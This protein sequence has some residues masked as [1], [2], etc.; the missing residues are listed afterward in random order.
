MP[1]KNIYL[2]PHG[3]EI[4]DRPGTGSERMNET[5]G[6]VT[7][8]DGS[9]VLV[10]ASPHG[11]RLSNSIP[12]VNTE[13]FEGWFGLK[14]KNLHRALPNERP[15]TELIIENSRGDCEEVGYVTVQGDKS[16]FPLD[17]GT[18]IPLE[19]FRDRPI[20]Y[21]G[22]SRISDRKKLRRFGRKLFDS[23]DQYEKSVSLIISADQSHTHSPN[24]PYGYSEESSTYEDIVKEAI[25]SNDFT[26]LVEMDD[27]L[28]SNAK[29]DSYWNLLVLT[30]FLEKSERRLELDYSY[31]E[32]YF[33]M[34]CAHSYR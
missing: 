9:D 13:R 25:V 33:G 18:L 29:P 6:K 8:N 11:V 5:I 7:G 22:Q 24:G 2:L 27:K 14:T 20:V 12:V 28:I 32:E 21:I 16:V 26:P 23:I 31:I 19:F 10:I 3:D 34:L 4:L 15:L 1:L 30:S 17:F